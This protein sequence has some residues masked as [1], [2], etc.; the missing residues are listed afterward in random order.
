[1]YTFFTIVKVYCFCGHKTQLLHTVN[2]QTKKSPPHFKPRIALGH[3]KLW[4][5]KWD[6]VCI[7]FT[8]E[9]LNVWLRNSC[10]MLK[11]NAAHEWSLVIPVPTWQANKPLCG[12]SSN[13]WLIFVV[14]LYLIHP[15]SY[16]SM[17]TI[18]IL[19]KEVKSQ[20]LK[21]LIF[22]TV[23]IVFHTY[24]VLEVPSLKIWV[25]E[26]TQQEFLQQLEIIFLPLKSVW[27][28]GSNTEG[29]SGCSSVRP[30]YTLDQSNRRRASDVGR[31]CLLLEVFWVSCSSCYFR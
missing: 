23:D 21:Y 22:S 17:M 30:R 28:A 12:L 16:N 6:M 15:W 27:T 11:N 1:M 8:R 7:P 3:V 2:F 29:I 20:S 26:M 4:S 19:N 24:T 31:H 9:E 18:Q 25:T 14:V 10:H 13:I 5:E